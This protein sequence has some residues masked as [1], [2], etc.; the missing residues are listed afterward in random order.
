M[1][2]IKFGEILLI[3]W[4][5]SEVKTNSE[6]REITAYRLI[7]MI[8][9]DEYLADCITLLRWDFWDRERDGRPIV[10]PRTNLVEEY[11]MPT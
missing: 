8:D 10:N 9:D 7:A 6:V 11:V 4:V 5:G 1:Y 2:I 3:N